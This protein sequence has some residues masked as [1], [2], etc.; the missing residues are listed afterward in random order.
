MNRFTEGSYNAED[1]PG[2]VQSSNM[3]EAVVQESEGMH[4]EP[5]HLEPDW[6]EFMFGSPADISSTPTNTRKFSHDTTFDSTVSVDQVLNS[7]GS[8]LTSPPLENMLDDDLYPT[9]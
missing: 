7:P 1:D 5:Q 9:Q 4:P 6:S 3:S 2:N 8:F